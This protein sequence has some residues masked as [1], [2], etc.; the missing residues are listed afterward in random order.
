MNEETIWK[1]LKQQGLSDAGV[2]GLMGNL[3]AE[4]GLCPNNLQDTYNQSLGLSDVE[5]TQVVDNGTYTGFINDSA[6]YGLVQWTASA[7]K[8]ALL[9]FSKQQNKSIG[10]LSMQLDFLMQELNQ[11]FSSVL[12][13]LKETASVKEASDIVLYKFEAPANA[14]AKSTQRYNMSMVYYNKF[15]KGDNT[16][17]TN[18][19][20]KGQK[21]QL[22]QY[23]VSTEFDCH[24]NG[25]CSTTQINPLLVERLN[26]IREHFNAPITISSGYRC[27]THNR[28]VGGAT[29]S[30][31]TA[32]DAADIIVKGHTPRE[33]AQYAESIGIKGIGLY[34]TAADGHFVHIDTRDAKSFWYGQ[35][36]AARTTFG[37]ITTTTTTAKTYMS[38]GDSGDNVKQLQK[39]LNSVGANLI[40]D[41]I[42]GSGTYQAVMQFQKTKGLAADGIAGQKTMDA[43]YSA[44][45]ATA[46][47]TT[48]TVIANLLNV[49]QGP[50]TQYSIV[51]RISKGATYQLLE[52]SNG[53][54]RIDKGWVSMQY[55]S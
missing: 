36:C 19:Y 4:S 1:F 23:F 18:T 10:D 54:G 33:V 25:C 12:K 38:M 53:W 49:R 41:G 50:G 13:T 44:T 55:V 5:Y 16:M 34:E 35:A 51:D 40:E 24:G 8:R 47:K 46:A 30:R 37:D 11:S 2:A 42:Y 39:L 43:L 20:V 7:R 14:S 45:N 9:N 22:S 17:S 32:G 52:T 26:Q 48:I 29:G 27:P 28:N 21:K 31:H 15:A 6:G 3:N